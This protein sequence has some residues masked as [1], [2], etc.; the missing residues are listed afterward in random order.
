MAYEVRWKKGSGAM[1]FFFDS[2][3]PNGGSLFVSEKNSAGRNDQFRFDGDSLTTGLFIRADK[4]TFRV[5]K[6]SP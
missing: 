2:Q 1:M 4:K 5:R 3:T 6:I